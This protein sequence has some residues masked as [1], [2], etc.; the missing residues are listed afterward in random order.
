M[1][2]CP[3][4]AGGTR[5]M[6]MKRLFLSYFLAFRVEAAGAAFYLF[7]LACPR[8]KQRRTQT[9]DNTAPPFDHAVI[10]LL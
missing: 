4:L 5:S 2:T 3:D 7:F 1:L 9:A 8:K 10:W 6:I